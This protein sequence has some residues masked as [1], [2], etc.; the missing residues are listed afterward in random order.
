[1]EKQVGPD[2][3]FDDV[4]KVL[5]FGEGTK[6]WIVSA[7]FV[8]SPHLSAFGLLIWLHLQAAGVVMRDGGC[9]RQ[10]LD[11]GEDCLNRIPAEKFM[12]HRVPFFV[13][14]GNLLRTEHPA[15]PW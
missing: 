5:R 15:S 2:Q 9:C 12:H 6:S 3:L 4:E 7:G 8:K 1:M 13:V 11:V 14:L 10:V